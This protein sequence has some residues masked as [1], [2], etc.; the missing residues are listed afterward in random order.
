M[1]DK[2]KKGNV[3]NETIYFS[4]PECA[5]HNLAGSG[6]FI[7]S[8]LGRPWDGHGEAYLPT[9]L[10]S[11]EAPY[12]RVVELGGVTSGIGIG[13]DYGFIV[14]SEKEIE[15]E[16]NINELQAK[17]SS[18]MKDAEKSEQEKEKIEKELAE[19]KRYTDLKDILSRVSNYAKEKLEN[20]EKFASEFSKEN[21]RTAFVLS[22]DIRRSTDLMLNAIKPKD[23]A[24]FMLSLASNLSL[25]I[26]KYFGIVEKFTG[27]GILGF[28]P[29]FFS[30][31]DAGYYCLQSSIRCHELFRRI[32]DE[33]IP[34][35]KTTI[36]ETGLGIGIDYGEIF[37]S[38]LLSSMNII[39]DPVVYA[40]RMSG[41][42]AGKTYINNRALQ[43]LKERYPGHI[44]TE[45]AIIE[46]KHVGKC[47]ANCFE[48]FAEVDKIEKPEWLK[49]E[50]DMESAK[51]QA[52][53]KKEPKDE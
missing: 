18:T 50:K 9:H 46:L 12:T 13:H 52:G 34:R 41:A 25:I 24:D 53:K 48:Y 36:L 10:I 42:P 8:S 2:F 32:Y 21:M 14:K 16:R 51:K 44:K 1:G 33:F 31:K 20:D 6:L 30:G 39:G 35:F 38:R 11:G 4:Q 23:F 43:A 15:L 37:V 49:D 3:E 29:D 28:F 40:C 27:D 45:D 5:A 17:L 19:L 47:R 26:K 22:I 7:E